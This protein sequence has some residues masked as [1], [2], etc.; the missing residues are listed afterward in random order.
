M[1]QTDWQLVSML[2]TFGFKFGWA[3]SG[4]YMKHLPIIVTY[5]HWKKMRIGG[6]RGW[7]KV[8]KLQ[9]EATS[10]HS[11]VLGSQSLFVTWQDNISWLNMLGQHKYLLGMFEAYSQPLLIPQGASALYFSLNMKEKSIYFCVA[12][13]F[14][15]YYKWPEHDHKMGKIWSHQG[16]NNSPLHVF[17]AKNTISDS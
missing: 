14:C 8:N 1:S 5:F 16:L 6:V 2:Q 12:A 7:N 11:H 10:C 13:N 4:N 9:K 3:M 15:T 17:S